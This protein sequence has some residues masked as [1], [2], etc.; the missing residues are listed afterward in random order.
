MHD[1]NSF[2]P[3]AQRISGVVEID[4]AATRSSF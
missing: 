4:Y 3:I 1:K 2:W